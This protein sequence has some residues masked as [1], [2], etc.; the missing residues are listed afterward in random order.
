MCFTLSSNAEQTH[1]LFLCH[2]CLSCCGSKTFKS[3]EPSECGS[4]VAMRTSVAE[5]NQSQGSCNSSG[6]CYQTV[7]QCNVSTISSK[8]DGNQTLKVRPPSR[9]CLQDTFWTVWQQHQTVLFLSQ[10]STLKS[11]NG[12]EWRAYCNL[13]DI[14]Q[15]SSLLPWTITLVLKV[16]HNNTFKGNETLLGIKMKKGFLVKANPWLWVW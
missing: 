15:Y 12:S 16:V 5:V 11:R 9:V 1:N 14:G 8:L 3:L 10:S 4:T 13:N 7:A 6:Q 2:I